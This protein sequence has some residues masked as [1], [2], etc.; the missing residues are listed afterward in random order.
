MREI[1]PLIAALTGIAAAAGLCLALVNEVTKDPIEAAEKENRSRAIRA[2]LPDFANSPDDE[3]AWI[4]SGDYSFF[5]AKDEGEKMVGVAFSSSS[6]EGYGGQIDVMVGLVPDADAYKINRIEIVKHLETPGLGSKIAE[7]GFKGQFENTNLG[8]RT[9]EV[10]KDNPGTPDRPPIDAIT[11]A[12]I[13]SRAVTD[14]VR[15]GITYFLEHKD[16]IVNGGRK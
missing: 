14:A 15:N 3:S 6:I 1:L 7:P 4:G 16:E 12:T 11:G 9:F 13:S 10:K 5:L 2:V 8:N